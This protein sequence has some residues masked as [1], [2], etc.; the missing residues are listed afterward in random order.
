VSPEELL[1]IERELLLLDVCAT[2]TTAPP[3]GGASATAEAAEADA[4]RGAGA[5]GSDSDEERQSEEARHSKEEGQSGDH[6]GKGPL[7]ESSAGSE[8]R[9]RVMDPWVLEDVWDD[10]DYHHEPRNPNKVRAS[11]E[12]VDL[13]CSHGRRERPCLQ[14]AHMTICY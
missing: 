5:A 4:G 9:V 13:V 11:T 1:R 3:P 10:D 7:P 14:T 6:E 8:G 2:S 12:R